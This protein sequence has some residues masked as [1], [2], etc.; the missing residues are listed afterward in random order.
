MVEPGF[1]WQDTPFHEQKMRRY[2]DLG[3]TR[4][5]DISSLWLM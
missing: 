3:G 5:A 2:Q 1:V 4:H